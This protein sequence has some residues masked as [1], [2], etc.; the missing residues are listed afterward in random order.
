[1]RPQQEQQAMAEK[2]LAF[3]NQ[4]PDAPGDFGIQEF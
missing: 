3:L 1:M 2:M 4:C